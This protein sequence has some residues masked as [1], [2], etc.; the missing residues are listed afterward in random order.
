MSEELK[1]IKFQLM[2]GPLEAEAIDDWG[3][4]HR[5]RTRAEAIRRLCKIGLGRMDQAHEVLLAT[6]ELLDAADGVGAERNDA[7]L[8]ELLLLKVLE[9]SNL[10][11]GRDRMA[12]EFRTWSPLDPKEALAAAS[13]SG[14]NQNY[15]RKYVS[16][17][18]KYVL[19]D[20]EETEDDNI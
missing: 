12:E 9:L 19:N 4:A 13:A 14:R 10:L 7:A 20:R 18:K 5:I 2:L 6:V 8:A 16:E 15:L 17:Y 11:M 1:T 3:F